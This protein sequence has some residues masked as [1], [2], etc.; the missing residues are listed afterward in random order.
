MRMR[1][2]QKVRRN[3]N[4]AA[5]ARISRPTAAG[6]QNGV[7]SKHARLC[8]NRARYGIRGSFE[9]RMNPVRL[10]RSSAGRE[11]P[12]CERVWGLLPPA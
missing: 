10:P 3:K 9:Y 4:L 2:G 5:G 1:E 11:G 6:H 8:T 7:R 12:A